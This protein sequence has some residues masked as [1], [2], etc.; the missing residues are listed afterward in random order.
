MSK[1]FS[2]RQLDTVASHFLSLLPQKSKAGA[3]TVKADKG[4]GTLGEQILPL[5]TEYMK[6]MDYRP[7]PALSTSS[8]DAALWKGMCEY[9]DRSRIPYNDQGSFSWKCFIFGATY[10]AVG[11][12]IN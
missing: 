11:T 5:L 9:A 4:L 2:I 8:T 6:D 7:P 10:A 3:V 1:R 12:P